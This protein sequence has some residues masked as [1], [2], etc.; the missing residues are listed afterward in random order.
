MG[1]QY[2]CVFT[3]GF[4]YCNHWWTFYLYK[5]F[6]SFE[7]EIHLPVCVKTSEEENKQTKKAVTLISILTAPFIY[8]I[9]VE[10]VGWLI[11]RLGGG[12]SFSR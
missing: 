12:V 10:Q 9:P 5:Y 7:Y 6:L 2:I 4:T 8:F 11:L 3:H 1:K